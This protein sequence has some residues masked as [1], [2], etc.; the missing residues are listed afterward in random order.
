MSPQY[1]EMPLNR[2]LLW[3]GVPVTKDIQFILRGP[4]RFGQLAGK[5]LDFI[6]FNGTADVWADFEELRHCIGARTV[7]AVNMYGPAFASRVEQT[8]NIAKALGRNILHLDF[9]QY[10]SGLGIMLPDAFSA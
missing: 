10:D 1:L 3:A 8:R 6:F 5:K 4:N 9:G 7:V 2:S